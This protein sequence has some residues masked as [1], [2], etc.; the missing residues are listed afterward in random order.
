MIYRLPA[1]PPVRAYAV[2]ALLCLGGAGLLLGTLAASW[3]GWVSVA[4]VLLLLL[5]LGLV[6]AA[7]VVRRR[8]GVEVELSD[9]GYV[10]RGAGEPLRGT[11]DGVTKVTQSASGGLTLHHGDDARTRLLPSG[12]VPTA[13]LA[14]LG[15]D[16]ARHLDRSRGYGGI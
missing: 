3:P 12:Y 10:I 1:Q 11:W 2:A 8:Q 13:Q 14:L 5:G 4:A 7:E 6:T 16:I 15:R 9:Q